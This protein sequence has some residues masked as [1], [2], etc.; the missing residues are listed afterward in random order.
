M[1]RPK[2]IDRADLVEMRRATPQSQAS[3]RIHVQS[4]EHTS[5][6]AGDATRRLAGAYPSS[7]RTSIAREPREPLAAA[8]LEMDCRRR[9]PERSAQPGEDAARLE[10]QKCFR[11]RSQEKR[12]RESSRSAGGIA[13]K[14]GGGGFKPSSY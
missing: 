9:E 10:R 7:Q 11:A 3:H 8:L 2:F 12:T 4:S 5:R 14:F 1:V 6:S 13:Q